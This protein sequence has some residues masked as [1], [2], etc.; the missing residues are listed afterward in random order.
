MSD[1][2][3]TR[4]FLASA[5]ISTILCT[6]MLC[7]SGISLATPTFDRSSWT[8][9]HGEWDPTMSDSESGPSNFFGEQQQYMTCVCTDGS[10]G[11]PDYWAAGSGFSSAQEAYEP[12][13][14]WVNVAERNPAYMTVECGY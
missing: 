2:F 7:F 13:L 8:N 10:I 5:G 9:W 14:A 11:G 3:A 12:C 6:T 1:K 4:S